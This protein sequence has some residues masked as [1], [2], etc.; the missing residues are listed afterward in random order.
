[1]NEIIEAIGVKLEILLSGFV[2]AARVVGT[3]G[4]MASFGYSTIAVPNAGRAS[5]LFIE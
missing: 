4:T 1:M 5:K 3:T 2:F